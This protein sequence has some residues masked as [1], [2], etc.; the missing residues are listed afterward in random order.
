LQ[1]CKFNIDLYEGYGRDLIGK[2]IFQ[3]GAEEVNHRYCTHV[4]NL[5]GKRAVSGQNSEKP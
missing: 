2:V 3:K 5:S 4:M 1:I